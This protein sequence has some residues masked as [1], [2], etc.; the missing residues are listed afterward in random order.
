MG[1]MKDLYSIMTGAYDPHTPPKEGSEI[2]GRN[3]T[4]LIYKNGKFIIKNNNKKGEGNG[5]K[6]EKR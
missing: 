1:K 4:I 5:N 6:N 3:G 2:R